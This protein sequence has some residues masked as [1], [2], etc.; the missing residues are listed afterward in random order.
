MKIL[1]LHDWL[2]TPA[3]VKSKC[4][5]DHG[6]EVLNPALPDD[7]FDFAVRIAQ[8]KFDEYQ[9]DVV[10]GAGRDA[11]VA[12]AVNSGKTA[13]VLLCPDWNRWGAATTVKPKTIILHSP[14][15]KTVPI[16]KS[17]EL[18]RNSAIQESALVLV[19]QDHRLADPESLSAMLKAV[20]A[21]YKEG[22]CRQFGIGHLFIIMTMYALLFSALQT[23]GCPPA[24]VVLYTLFLT[25]VGLGQALLYK[26]RRPLRASM[27]MGACFSVGVGVVCMIFGLASGPWFFA[28][29]P[30]EGAI[31]GLIYGRIISWLFVVID[32]L[33]S[34]LTK[35]LCR[36]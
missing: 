22:S 11:A 10:V 25:A 4:L 34:L 12:M 35:A 36:R 29:D 8:A 9:P 3:D 21:S 32:G 28:P 18:L 13:L 2:S 31:A 19:G 26:G 23:L 6:H 15:D 24:A 30:V 17:Q 27:I 7:D 5:Q 1:F 14:A 33:R 20:D 16:A